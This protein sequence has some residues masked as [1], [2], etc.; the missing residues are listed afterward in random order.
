MTTE[1]QDACHD[2]IGAIKREYVLS[3][4]DSALVVSAAEQIYALCPTHD[5]ERV[6]HLVNGIVGILDEPEYVGEFHDAE[7]IWKTLLRM[8]LN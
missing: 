3:E 8:V 4:N 2:L 7:Y 5:A 1:L 6:K